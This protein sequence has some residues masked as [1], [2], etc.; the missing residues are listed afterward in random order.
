IFKVVFVTY[1]VRIVFAFVFN[2]KLYF[3]IPL[4]E[5]LAAQVG[6]GYPIYFKFRGGKGVAAT[7]GLL[8][9]INVFLSPIAGV[10]FFLLLFK[11]KYVSLSSLLTI[12][13]MIGF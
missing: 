12:L 13:I 11:T 8:I 3:Y 10:F 1:F 4:I 2:P 6:Q 5:G 7:V 9:S